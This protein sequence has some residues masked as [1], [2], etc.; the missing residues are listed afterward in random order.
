MDINQFSIYSKITKNETKAGD[1][2]EKV[3]ELVEALNSLDEMSSVKTYLKENWGI[4]D[5][6]RN[7]AITKNILMNVTTGKKYF[8]VTLM[9]ENLVES[10]NFNKGV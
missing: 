4:K 5:D 1:D 10:Y 8:N 7:L 9:R 3:N 2:L 6:I